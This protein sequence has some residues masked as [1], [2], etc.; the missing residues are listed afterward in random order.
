MLKVREN[1]SATIVS[2]IF[3][4]QNKVYDLGNPSAF[5]SPKVRS[6]FHDNTR[7]LNTFKRKLRNESHKPEARS[8]AI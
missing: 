4:K 2:K 1:F 3:Q 6:D 8:Q 7:F 5:V